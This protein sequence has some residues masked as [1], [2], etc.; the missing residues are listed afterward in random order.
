M[1]HRISQIPMYIDFH[2]FQ[3]NPINFFINQF[4]N[5]LK[6]VHLKRNSYSITIE[7]P[8]IK[9]WFSF[10][11]QNVIPINTIAHTEKNKRSRAIIE[12]R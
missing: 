2:S 11:L 3:N 5:K 6:S 9:K 10:F 7:F 8:Q 1:K 4:I 12:A